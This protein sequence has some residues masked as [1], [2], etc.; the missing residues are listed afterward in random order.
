MQDSNISVPVDAEFILPAAGSL[1][2][3]AG[4]HVLE[5][6]VHQGGPARDNLPLGVDEAVGEDGHGL[7]AE[8]QLLVEV[9]AVEH[10]T[11]HV[12]VHAGD[13]GLV[14]PVVTAIPVP[15]SLPEIV[16]LLLFTM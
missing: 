10:A 2:R 12:L 8:L 16:M 1:G 11:D 13:V 14:E 7:H 5:T 4:I 15:A 6:Q 3:E 9:G